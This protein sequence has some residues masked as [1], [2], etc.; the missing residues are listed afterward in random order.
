MVLL[1]SHKC[2]NPTDVFSPTSSFQPNHFESHII[3]KPNL[4]VF[5]QPEGLIPE[6]QHQNPFVYVFEGRW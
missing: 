3:F 1:K 5:V 6:N 2:A 4:D